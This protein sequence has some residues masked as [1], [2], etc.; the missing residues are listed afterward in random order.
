MQFQQ[1]NREWRDAIEHFR[2]EQE[3]AFAEH[4]YALPQELRLHL[5]A[6]STEAARRLD[7]MLKV[8]EHR[9]SELRF[10]KGE[11]HEHS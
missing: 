4:G 6:L 1:A 11:P 8:T 10:D 2:R 7:V 3:R 5:L 9:A